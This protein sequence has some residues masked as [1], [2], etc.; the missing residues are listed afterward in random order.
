MSLRLRICR[1]I[2]GTWSVHGLSPL[3]VAHLP[4]LSASLDYARRECAAAPA[5]IELLIDGFYAVVHQEEGWPRPPLTLKARGP[6]LVDRGTGTGGRAVT[7]R[8]S[9]ATSV[10][11]SRSSWFIN[12]RAWATRSIAALASGFAAMK[13]SK[14][15]F[16]STSSRQ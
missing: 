11:R 3:P 8:Y 9:D 4:S 16:L 2:C 7:M 12:W 10:A 13:R 15:V 1:D 5:T 6:R 14:S